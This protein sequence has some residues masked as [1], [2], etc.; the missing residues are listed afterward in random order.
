M[1]MH[2]ILNSKDSMSLLM[3]QKWY[4][5]MEPKVIVSNHNL[6]KMVIHHGTSPPT[7]LKFIVFRMMFNFNTEFEDK[8]DPVIHESFDKFYTLV[9][10]TFF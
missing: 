1:L 3:T 9:T 7:C 6:Q 2:E 4:I 5:T 8:F 10:Y